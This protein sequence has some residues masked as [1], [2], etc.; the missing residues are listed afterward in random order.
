MSDDRDL[1]LS[2]GANLGALRVIEKALKEGIEGARDKDLAFKI[3]LA[4][5]NE[6]MVTVMRYRWHETEKLAEAVTAVVRR[7]MNEE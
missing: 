3:I 6:G 2:V 7:R 1:T 5:L 4:L